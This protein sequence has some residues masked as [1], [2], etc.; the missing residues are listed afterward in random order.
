MAKSSKA[1]L[2]SVVLLSL[3][4]LLGI[5]VSGCA[6][7]SDDPDANY[8]PPTRSDRSS[9]PWNRPQSWEGGAV[10]GFPSNFGTR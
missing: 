7:T 2:R 4:G 1:T 5:G 9:I 10:P 8:R 6:S 3:V